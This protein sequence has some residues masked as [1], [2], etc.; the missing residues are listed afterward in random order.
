MSSRTTELAFLLDLS[1][2]A[3]V[4]LAITEG[5]KLLLDGP[6]RHNLGLETYDI[7]ILTAEGSGIAT[8]LPLMASLAARRVYDKSESLDK[9]LFRDQTRRVDL[10]WWLDDNSQAEWVADQ[11]AH[12]KSL[13]PENVWGT[14][15]SPHAHI[16]IRH[17]NFSSRG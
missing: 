11:L 2:H 16:L 6:Y 9:T 1:K 5:H 12:L 3:R 15:P 14:H 10:F 4:S 7:V 13:D 17:R 8:V